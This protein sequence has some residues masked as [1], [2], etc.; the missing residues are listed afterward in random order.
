[1]R[2]YH[3]LLVVSGICGLG[4]QV[5]WTRWFGFGLGHELAGVMGVVGAFFL[6][7]AVGAWA[8]DRALAHSARP[9][10]WYVG[11]EVLI[12]AWALIGIVLIPQVDE[13]AAAALGRAPSALL[14]GALATLIPAL[15]LLPATVAMG[16][17]LPAMER[18]AA[19]GA[20]SKGDEPR[21]IV[22]GLYAANTVGAMLGTIAITFWMLPDLG[23]KAATAVLAVLNLACAGGALAL[24]A[25]RAA[26]TGAETELQ[27][28]ARVQSPAG[29]A[30]AAPSPELSQKRL[31]WTLFA[32]GFLGIAYETIG[33][34]MLTQ[35]LENTVY[36]F[37]VVLSV[38]LA[39]TALGAALYQRWL[40]ALRIES[41][42]GPLLAA[43]SVA[44][45]G[46]ACSMEY[47][48]EVHA[49]L[50]EEQGFARALLSE[51]VLAAMVFL[52]P[53][54]LMG[55]TFA[56]LAQALRRAEGGLGKAL[57]VNTLGSSLA[58]SVSGWL[59]APFIGLRWSICLVALGYGALAIGRAKS[60]AWPLVTI[61]ALGW[62]A[63]SDLDLVETDDNEKVLER[64]DG[65]M[66]SVTITERT[67]G[68]R[69]LRVDNHFRMGGTQSTFFERRQGMIPL[70]LHPDP[71]RALFLGLGSGTTLSA[72]TF[73]SDLQTDGVELVPEVLTALPYFSQA[74]AD[75]FSHPGIH[76]TA[77]DARRF[78]RASPA[79]YD[80][81]VADLFQPA[82]DGAG[83]LYTVEHFEATRD[84]LREG[85]LFCQWLPLYQ[86]EEEVAAMI[87]RS[88]LEVFPHADAYIG[89]FNAVTPALALIG[90]SV[91]NRVDPKILET[92]MST[93]GL[94]QQLEALALDDIFDLL[95]SR[96]A[97]RE[98]LESFADGA[99]LNT[100]DLPIVMFT[101]PAFIYRARAAASKTLAPF[102]NREPASALELLPEDDS[103]PDARNLVARI[104]AYVRAR[105]AYI[106]GQIALS[107]SR[108]EA[109][110][111][112][113]VAS[114]E[115]SKDFNAG[116]QQ[117]IT[118]ANTARGISKAALL[119]A[120]KAVAAARPEL[121]DLGRLQRQFRAS[122]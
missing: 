108:D 87:T 42:Y 20:R 99:P 45:L 52:A 50:G 62:I 21:R 92:R 27:G 32:T 68:V 64:F 34:R 54:I 119:K 73:F 29:D 75:V 14:H 13:I 49:A 43:L 9:G 2:T 81:I 83:A 114:V 3:A 44:C 35:V 74:N 63:T 112:A 26:A 5:I 47:A 113:Y 96:I 91:E 53:T 10:L 86:M 16:A 94:S 104:E 37:A 76:L 40:S 88:F 101:A 93:P 15:M 72:A 102:L 25:R 23:F 56:A 11:L 111:D 78:V 79:E 58:P 110:L 24:G 106:A 103:S 36:T 71:K 46:G 22:G 118:L 107:E 28:K 38:Y 48:R 70:L 122:R 82:R 39:G 33:I 57:A 95:G 4:Y 55:A 7:L 12:A 84:S 59:L 89:A 41:I 116:Y 61:L 1:M 90:S 17:T 97:N 80:V 100:D 105:D 77:A 69:A 109:A 30:Q 6:G 8:F 98:Q 117:V 31:L 66:A 19:A 121:G 120:I 115:A 85:G 65:V 51:S 60:V 18:F 67:D